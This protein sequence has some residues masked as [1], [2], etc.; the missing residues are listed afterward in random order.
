MGLLAALERFLKTDH[1]AERRKLQSRAD[2]IIETLARIEGVNARIHVPEIANELPH[3]AIEW[4]EQKL[5]RTSQEVVR[6]LRE[7]EPPI[8]ISRDGQGKLRISVWM[9][10][11]DEHRI[12][13]RRLKEI[14]SQ[15]IARS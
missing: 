13:A 12:V 3:V 2:H 14:W 11:G 10:Q 15:G 9:M 1:A 8:I 5:G 6:Q 4:D 7:G